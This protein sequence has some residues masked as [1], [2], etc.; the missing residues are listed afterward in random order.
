VSGSAA[1]DEDV[2]IDPPFWRAISIFRWLTLGYA[3][4]VNLA[5][6]HNVEHPLAALAL[7]AVMSAWT[8]IATVAY[9][10]P[11]LRQ[12]PLL[13]VDLAL[14]T[15]VV[16]ATRLVEG[17]QRIAAGEPTFPQMWVAGALLAWA[18]YWRRRG[19]LVA[20]G[21]LAVADVVE[22]GGLSADTVKGIVILVL[23][24]LV[25]GHGVIM[26]R[27]AQA[28]L[29][30]AVRIQG[31]TR[32]RDRLSR[33]I[34]DSVLQVLALVQRRGAEIGGEAAEL[35]RL[36]GEQEQALRGLVF[37]SPEPAPAG[38]R[39][40]LRELISTAQAGPHVHLSAP[41]TPV[42]VSEHQARELAAAVSAAMHNVWSHVAADADVWVLVEDEGDATVVTIRDNG[43]GIAPGRLEQAAAEGRLGVAQSLR[44]R[45][46]DLGGTAVITSVVGDG[47]EVELRVPR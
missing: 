41:A 44:G 34:H 19:G 33:G 17:A 9:S 42:L 10:R 4:V 13:V 8:V 28:A 46:H 16:L 47:T 45:L 11:E 43:P 12:W 26:V 29:E 31:A 7:L 3:A 30:A 6:L 27:R 22:R 18:V 1:G 38:G 39:V 20:A 2:G 23:V 21:V 37:L 32:E 36:A 35:G 40:D 5:D 15:A 25:V 24:G 14:A